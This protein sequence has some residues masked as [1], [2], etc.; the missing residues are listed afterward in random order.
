MGF[1]YKCGRAAQSNNS[2][3]S[4]CEGCK[5]KQ[6]DDTRLNG[7]E[8]EAQLELDRIRAE[9]IQNQQNS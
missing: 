1:C 3:W 2:G 7:A 5:Q 6:R 8:F 9:R 4:L